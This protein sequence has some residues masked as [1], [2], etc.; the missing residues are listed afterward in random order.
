MPICH[1]SLALSLFDTLDT[2]RRDVDG[3]CGLGNWRNWQFALVER[4]FDGAARQVAQEGFPRAIMR[5]KDKRGCSEAN[6]RSCDQG[7]SC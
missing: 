1:F 3:F 6:E 2:D 7:P 4:W 5:C